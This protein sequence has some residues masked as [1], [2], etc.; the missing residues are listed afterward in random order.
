MP[1]L[2]PVSHFAKLP[3]S[4]LT[5]PAPALQLL[6]L[7][8]AT[9]T[10]CTIAEAQCVTGWREGRV[11]DAVR[12]LLQAGYLT[13]GR[14]SARDPYRHQVTEE[15]ASAYV[16]VPTDLLGLP[17]H[18]FAAWAHLIRFSD[19]WAA[20]AQRGLLRASL[21]KVARR[22]GLSRW[23]LG[24]AIAD[25][26]KAGIILRDGTE[27]RLAS[28][29]GTTKRDP[30]TETCQ[31][32]REAYQTARGAGSAMVQEPPN[33]MA[34][35]VAGTTKRATPNARARM[36]TYNAEDSKPEARAAATHRRDDLPKPQ[37]ALPD[38]AV[39]RLAKHLPAEVVSALG[40]MPETCRDAVGA[41]LLARAR[42]G[43]DPLTNPAGYLRILSAAWAAGGE[44]WS[45]ATEEAAYEWQEMLRPPPPE[46]LCVYLE[47]ECGYHGAGVWSATDP[48][49]TWAPCPTCGEELQLREVTILPTPDA[50]EDVA[51]ML[52]QRGHTPP[53]PDAREDVA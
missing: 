30:A 38:H 52:W 10:P 41:R 50:R 18:T 21:A 36:K 51:W 40:A 47:C 3:F 48:E 33:E 32:P 20:W 44:E 19:S 25:A 9:R 53:T 8:T 17:S 12:E 4:A 2:H 22:S 5:L 13:R 37:N 6:A 28:V 11:R 46:K 45:P 39:S 24:R 35:D 7:L 42:R 49:P 29:A 1:N 43:P 15:P 34:D 27:L 26:V 16:H 14:R 23:T 31:E